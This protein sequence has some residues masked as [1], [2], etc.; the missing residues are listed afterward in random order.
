MLVVDPATL[1]VKNTIPVGSKPKWIAVDSVNHTAYVIDAGD[2]T[3][4]I[5]HTA[6]AMVT[7]TVPI[8][9]TATATAADPTTHTAYITNRNGTLTV[10]THR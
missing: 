2:T 5:I 9:G 10:V 8:D 4:S 3:V 1:T 7:G 6:K